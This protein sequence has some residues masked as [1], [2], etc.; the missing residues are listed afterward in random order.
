VPVLLVD[1]RRRAVAAVHTGWRGTAAGASAAAV[2]A[3]RDA[4]D[5]RPDDLIAAIGPAIGPCC[6]EVDAP[7]YDGFARWPW[8][9]AV[10]LPA[11]DGRWMHDLWEANRRQ[12]VEARVR[13]DAVAVSAVCT[14]CQAPFFFS[15]RRDGSTGRMAGM[16]AVPSR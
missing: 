16:I 6:Y 12:L 9:D 4:F 8:R 1:P 2:R 13:A 14:S 3:M 15:H 5:S 10:F 11:G 7:V